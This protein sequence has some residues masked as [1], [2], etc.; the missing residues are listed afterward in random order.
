MS[1]FELLQM[2]HQLNF[3]FYRTKVTI[4]PEICLFDAPARVMAEKNFRRLFAPSK[5][6][7]SRG[8]ASHAL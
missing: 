2:R 4:D 1:W 3:A 7:E 8:I 6:S 5:E